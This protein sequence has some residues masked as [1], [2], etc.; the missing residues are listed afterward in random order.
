LVFEDSGSPNKIKN[1][2]KK[3]KKVKETM[4]IPALDFEKI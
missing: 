4:K 2:N 1:S 3:N